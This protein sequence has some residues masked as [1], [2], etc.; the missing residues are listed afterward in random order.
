MKPI[1]NRKERI[2]AWTRFLTALLVS[3]ALFSLGFIFAGNVPGFIPIESNFGATLLGDSE[4]DNWIKRH[5]KKETCE[6]IFDALKK[7]ILKNGCQ[8]TRLAVSED[9]ILLQEVLDQIEKKELTLF[10]KSSAENE[11]MRFLY[12]DIE[13]KKLPAKLEIQNVKIVEATRLL[14]ERFYLLDN[15]VL[16]TEGLEL[17]Q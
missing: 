14:V 4:L 8:L 5:N 2:W 16:F 9:L 10:W 17:K 15:K 11:K 1:K 13:P 7:G 12:L 3:L 6:H